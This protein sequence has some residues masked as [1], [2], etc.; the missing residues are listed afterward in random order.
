MTTVFNSTA[1]ISVRSTYT[2]FNQVDFLVQLRN[3]SIQAN[4]FRL[5]GKIRVQKDADNN[6]LA[7][8]GVFFNAFAGVS[9]VINVC[10]TSI[11]S[12]QIIE[13]ISSFGRLVA[14]KKQSKYTLPQLSAS[15]A[16]SLELCGNRNN[17]LLV[18]E[19]GED[20]YVSF[21]LAIDNCL[22]NMM[23]G[24]IHPAKIN[25]VRLM[26]TLESALNALYIN[27]IESEIGALSYTLKDLLLMWTEVPALPKPAPIGM[28]T[29]FLTQQTLVSKNTNLTIMSGTS[30]ADALSIS[31]IRQKNR[32]KKDRDGLLS[33]FIGEIQRVE[34]EINSSQA[35][36]MYPL[37][38]YGDMA[39][40]Y[41]RSFKSPEDPLMKNSITSLATYGTCAFGLG[42]LYPESQLNRLTM[43]IT[44]AD[45]ARPENDPSLIDGHIDAFAFTNS[46]LSL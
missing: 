2:E 26:L 10:S 36:N 39:L 42:V 38:E 3:N 16:A 7:A 5:N 11:N 46:M 32:S 18:G 31:F 13:N 34:F 12:T 1:P 19:V 9:S 8:D 24:D 45:N 40:N 29:Y 20:G 14:M 22:N 44:I 15:S 17:Q 33:E 23:G 41:Y 30:P 35:V 21:S 6:I 28:I 4:S 27:N 37:L 25:E 43:T